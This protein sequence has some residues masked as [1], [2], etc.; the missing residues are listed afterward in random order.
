MV[1]FHVTFVQTDKG[2]DG[3]TDRL[4]DGKTICPGSFDTGA[5]K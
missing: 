1:S 3:W 5:E 2:M 4:T